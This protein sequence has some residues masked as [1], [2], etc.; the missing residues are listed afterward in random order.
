MSNSIQRAAVRRKIVYG[1]LILG[2]FTL[3][4]FWRGKIPLPLSDDARAIYLNQLRRDGGDEFSPPPA[5]NG[6][7]RAAD[8]L[9]SRTIEQ[10]AHPEA[11]DLRELEQGD[12]DIAGALM[13]RVLVGS[14]GIAVAITWRAAIEK[15]KRNEFHEFEQLVLLVT[16][17]QPNFITPWI[18]QSWNIAYNISVENDRLNDMYYYIARGIEL[19]AEGERMNKKSPD[20][21]FQTA[22]YYQNKFSVSDKVTT[23]RS[24]FQLSCMKPEERNP[25][26]YRTEAGID[27]PAFQNFVRKNPQLVR[28]L[29]EKLGY[30]R[31]EQIVQFLEDNSRVP[32]RYDRERQD[33]LL[34]DTEQFPVLPPSFKEG[35][36]EANPRSET[37]DTFDAFLASRAW[38]SYSKVDLPPA[39]KKPIATPELTAEGRFRYRIPKSPMLII[40]R[41]GAARV[42]TYYA[43]RLTKEGW[44][45]RQTKWY[46][47]ERA[48]QD[49]ELWFNRGSG[50]AGI[51]EPLSTPA[52]SQAEWAKAYAMW[53]EHGEANGLQLD[54]A[55]L[56]RYTQLAQGV[57]DDYSLT[58]LSDAQLKLIGL[59]AE[60]V[61]AR[62]VLRTY[63]QNRYVT[64]FDFFLNSANAEQDS[65]TI[66]ARRKL[67]EA[68][69]VEKSGNKLKAPMLYAEGL[70][71]LRQVTLKFP[72]FQKAGSSL[73]GEEDYY[74][75]HVALVRLLQRS[76]RIE[77]L[78]K[79][80]ALALRALIPAADEDIF[81]EIIARDIADRE[82][83]LMPS[84][85]DPRVQ[86]EVDRILNLAKTEPKLQETWPVNDRDQLARAV[87]ARSF[88]WIVTYK[89]DLRDD[90]NRWVSLGTVASTNDRIRQPGETITG[91]TLQPAQPEQAIP[92][93]AN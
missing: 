48:D 51:G 41:Q 33:Q 17:L 34:P 15:Q 70:A 72:E 32:T 92:V 45:D 61:D 3:S 1:G 44:F 78:A 24:L 10:Q 14:R 36:N 12:A 60:R 50:D 43:E 86:A 59:S 85:L 26:R 56:L 49:D 81:K 27:M 62:S 54:Q 19:L 23:L 11:L 31:P 90:T 39:S 57:P 79:Q 38:Y 40:F 2:L 42:Q 20:M 63:D 47:D 28:R 77:L 73:K 67:M 80:Q 52:N 89:S 21:R 4:M 7:Y 9:A 87:V 30:S 82:A 66:E 68:E 53:K 74:E 84:L 88:P 18:Y 46:P 25:A 58:R 91:P 5:P 71:A 76:P 6:L 55:T 22:F 37:D 65:G 64:N 83:W 29:R 35:P 8:W 93:V 69:Q 13:R 16:R 75:T